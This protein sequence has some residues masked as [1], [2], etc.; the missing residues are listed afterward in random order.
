MAISI[1][2]PGRN[3]EWEF[4]GKNLRK[5]GKNPEWEFDGRSLRQL[6]RSTVWEVDG[7]VPIIVLAKVAGII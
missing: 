1:R 6:G 7:N 3:P 4:D 2:Q 5:P